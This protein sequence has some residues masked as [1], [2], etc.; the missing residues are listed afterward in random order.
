MNPVP[1]ESQALISPL[2]HSEP[3]ILGIKEGFKEKLCES[4]GTNA[5]S[6]VLQQDDRQHKSIDYYTLYKLAEAPIAG[7]HR[8]KATHVLK[9]IVSAITMQFD[10]HK[11]VMDNVALQKIMVNKAKAFGVIVNVSLIAVNLEANIEY[12]QSHEWGHEF[13]VSGQA[14]HKKYP[15]YSHNHDQT[16]YNNIIQEY[17]VADRVQV[18]WEARAPSKEQANLDGVVSG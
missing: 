4:G 1:W 8:P 12:A 6:L 9:Q 11:K 16:S 10:F 5:L 2:D 15:D 18:L 7:A 14:I 17:A 3:T 13:R